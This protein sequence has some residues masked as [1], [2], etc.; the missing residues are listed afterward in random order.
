MGRAPFPVLL[1]LNVEPRQVAE[2]AARSSALALTVG[3][4]GVL[5]AGKPWLEWR[6]DA[7]YCEELS[8]VLLDPLLH[9]L[10]G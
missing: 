4:T 6:V 5:G 10:R 3:P 2:S 8:G 9:I 7:R 1:F